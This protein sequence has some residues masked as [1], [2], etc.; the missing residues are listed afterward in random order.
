TTFEQRQRVPERCGTAASPVDRECVVEQR[1]P[2]AALRTAVELVGGCRNRCP[3]SDVFRQHVERD[4]R[5]EVRRVVDHDQCGP[6][7]ATQALSSVNAKRSAVALHVARDHPAA[8]H[9]PDYARPQA[10][11]PSMRFNAVALSIAN[12]CDL[13]RN[14]HDSLLRARTSALRSMCGVGAK[15]NLLH[16]ATARDLVSQFL[17]KSVCAVASDVAT[18]SHVRSMRAT[19]A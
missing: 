12:T 13:S 14:D 3:A 17:K 18:K 6:A 16:R 19:V 2:P 8:T 15:T 5:V 4:D 10:R 9:A 1:E 11:L 7:Y